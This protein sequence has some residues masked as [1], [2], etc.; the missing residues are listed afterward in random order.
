[1]TLS[2]CAKL[3]NVYG[4]ETTSGD[5]MIQK[6]ASKSSLHAIRIEQSGS[7]LD[8]VRRTVYRPYVGLSPGFHT[9]YYKDSFLWVFFGHPWMER[10][11]G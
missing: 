2:T 3:L 8:G 4:I 9:E 6:P 5:A 1:M 7:R 10:R 11:F